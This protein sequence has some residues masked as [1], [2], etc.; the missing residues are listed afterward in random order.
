MIQATQISEW[1]QLQGEGI[2]IV[3]LDS[4]V[5]PHHPQMKDY[6][7]DAGVS[8][9]AE[10]DEYRTN[11]DFTDQIGHGTAVT[12]I[13][14]RLVPQAE[15][16]TIQ[17]FR[18]QLEVRVDCL[19]RALE[20]VLT[21][22]DCHIVHMSL[23]ITHGGEVGPIR[24][25]CKQ[26]TDRG[27]IIVSAFDNDG[28]ISYPAGFPNVIGVDSAQFCKGDY[29]YELV[30]GSVVNI[31]AKGSYQRLPWVQQPFIFL[32]GASFAA[33]YV[34]A[35]VAKI[36]ESGVTDREQIL[37]VLKQDAVKVYEDKRSRD[38]HGQLFPIQRA[39]LFPFNK[40]MHSIARYQ[41]LLTFDVHGVY[42]TKYSGQ[43]GQPI[44]KLL[45][46]EVEHDHT[47][48]NFDTLDWSGDFDAVILGHV[49]LISQTIGSD[50]LERVVEL[51]IEHRKNIY[52]F[53]GLE[54]YSELVQRAEAAGIQIFNPGIGQHDIPP[55]R[56]GKLRKV[57]KPILGIFGTSS[58]QGKFTLQLQLR[59]RLLR[60]GYT[61]GQLGTEP[62][63]L[64]YGFDAV[65]P[66]G[67]GSTV[68]VGGYQAVQVLNDMMGRI[69]DRDPDLIIVGSQSGTVPYDI[70]HLSQYSFPALDFLLGTSPD[71]Y[72][73]CVNQEDDTAYIK[74]A[75]QVL[76]NLGIGKVIGLVIFPLRKKVHPWASVKME[77]SE[78][79]L[80]T[81]H[82]V[83]LQEEMGIPAF[84]LNSED[85]MEALFETMID[86]YS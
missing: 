65:Y 21:E 50:M 39:V 51:C 76:E 22:V 62:S 31:R 6:A 48:Q 68:K 80:I 24:D 1:K 49:D 57:G 73:L 3:V 19:V 63:A 72:I 34:S 75:V 20:H 53:D 77:A 17:V 61:I 12:S 42:D 32:G 40:E 16:Y 67:Y 46:G 58:R 14:K 38:E 43:V 85:D 64:L 83:K 33:P 82:K 29:E 9:I 25:L 18:D 44:S 69:E 54:P 45:R 8:I 74:R 4:G 66:M 36:V 78:S 41:D 13:I 23:G 11:E 71:S 79:V 10:G 84:V 2:K 52:C 70:G 37:S 27:T 30:E 55:N 28:A 5:N 35:Y 56:F 86:F 81:E 15:I 7:F 59:R 47:V 26:L 60:D